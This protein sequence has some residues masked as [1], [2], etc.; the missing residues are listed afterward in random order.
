M[1]R[2]FSKK[3]AFDRVLIDEQECCCG[4]GVK[5]EGTENTKA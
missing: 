4:L 1:I 2:R 5:D 3:T